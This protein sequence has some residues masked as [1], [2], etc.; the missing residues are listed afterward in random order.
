MKSYNVNKY[1]K[2]IH[3]DILCM[4]YHTTR[5]MK[6]YFAQWQKC[7]EKDGR[8]LK[9]LKRFKAMNTYIYASHIKRVYKWKSPCIRGKKKREKYKSVIWWDKTAKN[10]S[11]YKPGTE[12]NKKKIVFQFSHST[13]SDKMNNFLHFRAGQGRLKVLL[14]LQA[15]VRDRSDFKRTRGGYGRIKKRFIKNHQRTKGS[16]RRYGTM[17]GFNFRYRG[18][19]SALPDNGFDEEW[20]C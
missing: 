17:T 11:S 20:S 18:K 7:S 13:S 15:L 10:L 12:S 4:I 1:D 6:I 8:T 2:C 9:Y 5:V 3:F 14:R 19:K 16:V